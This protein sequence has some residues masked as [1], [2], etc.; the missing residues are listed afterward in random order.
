M[1]EPGMGSL[2]VTEPTGVEVGAKGK[3]GAVATEDL[4]DFRAGNRGFP[5]SE[6]RDRRYGAG[7]SGWWLWYSLWYNFFNHS[8]CGIHKQSVSS[9]M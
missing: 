8:V 6:I 1:T 9:S 2:T 5:D 7:S 4:I 3:L